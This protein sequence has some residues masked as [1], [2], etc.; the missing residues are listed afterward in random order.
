MRFAVIAFLYFLLLW[1]TGCAS[2]L[3][4]TKDPKVSLQQVAVREVNLAG[5]TLVFALK[6]ENPN[7]RDI[8]V[9][10]V[11]YKVFLSGREFAKARTEQEIVIPAGGTVTVELPL[12]VRYGDLLQGLDSLLSS[13]QLSYRIEGAAQASVFSIPFFKEGAVELR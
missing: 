2:L 4:Y 1:G 13:R 6:V 7:K 5:A 12:P 10:E 11:S 9:S 8:E 3:G